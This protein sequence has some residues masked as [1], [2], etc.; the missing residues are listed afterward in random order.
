MTRS[1]RTKIVR[2][3]LVAAGSLLAVSVL[4]VAVFLGAVPAP[5]SD[6]SPSPWTPPAGFEIEAGSRTAANAAPLSTDSPYG[7]EDIAIDHN[8]SAYTGDRDGRILRIGPDG[9]STVFANV[10]GRPLGLI[11]DAQQN[12]LIANH[13]I[14]LQSVSP[15]GAV[16]VLAS[17]AAGRPILFANDLVI[18]SDGRVWFTDS[19]ATYNTTT[20]GDSPSYLLPDLVDGR[21]TGRLLVFDPTSGITEQVLTDLYFPN[22]I[23]FPA[24][25]RTLWIAE[26][27]RYRIL[28]YDLTTRDRRVLVDAL[29]G[30]PDGINLDRDGS[31]LVALYDRSAALDRFVL[32]TT[33]GR[34]IMIRLPNSLFV[35]EEDPLTGGVLVLE[36]DGR[37]RHWHT[38]LSP[39]ATNV[40]PYEGRWYLGALLEQPLRAMMAPQ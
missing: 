18:A 5:V 9:N 10:G 27:N 14:G 15:E 37:V 7:P 40:V 16:T 12:L 4:A 28:E 3:V 35:N 6:F 2:G 11:F 39:A 32:P 20:L 22:G 36:P 29:P 31:M 8:G 21:P 26:S 33:L 13:G 30:V 24:H 1:R 19:S 23:A 25:G 17:E 38:G 34:Q